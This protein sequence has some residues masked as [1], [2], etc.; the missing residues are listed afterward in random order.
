MIK[1]KTKRGN[2][3]LNVLNIVSVEMRENGDVRIWCSNQGCTEATEEFDIVVKK[4]EK[5]LIRIAGGER[6]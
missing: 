1:V 5:M 6:V 4:I 2:V 3:F